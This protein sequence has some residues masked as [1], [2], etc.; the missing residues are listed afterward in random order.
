MSNTCSV[1]NVCIVHM[2]Q[3]DLI[4]GIMVVILLGMENYLKNSVL[5]Q[6]KVDLTQKKRNRAYTWKLVKK[7]LNR[8][9]EV[10]ALSDKTVYSSG[11]KNS[12]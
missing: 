5:P 11:K 1:D 6:G 9:R 4:Y 2:L 3:L 8:L 7:T 12:R 10:A